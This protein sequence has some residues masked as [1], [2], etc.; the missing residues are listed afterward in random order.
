MVL[1]YTIAI[2]LLLERTCNKSGDI[3]LYKMIWFDIKIDI[4]VLIDKCQCTHL[5]LCLFFHF[6]KDVWPIQRFTDIKNIIILTVKSYGLVYSVDN[7]V[8]RCCRENH[9]RNF[10][11]GR[12]IVS[13]FDKVQH[14]TAER[15]PM[16]KNVNVNIK[17]CANVSRLK[18]FIVPLM[19]CVGFVKGNPQGSRKI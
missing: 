14:C 10:I 6:K 1:Q 8:R 7:L 16:H 18:E 11:C 13:E 3:S 4:G 2:P 19:D 5:K 12:S 9:K 15:C 17:I